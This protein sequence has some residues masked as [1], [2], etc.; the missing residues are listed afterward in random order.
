[1]QSHSSHI[2]WDYCCFFT[3]SLLML[4]KLSPP[5]E[6]ELAQHSA[7]CLKCPT[8]PT[9]LGAALWLW[10]LNCCNN[11]DEPS[12][13]IF[14]TTQ[15]HSMNSSKCQKNICGDLWASTLLSLGLQEKKFRDWYSWCSVVYCWQIIST[16]GIT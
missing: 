8:M 16:C 5:V 11:S 3:A 10:L 1:M 13:P 7:L 6:G 9:A 15:Q 2:H 14:D 4:A 12:V